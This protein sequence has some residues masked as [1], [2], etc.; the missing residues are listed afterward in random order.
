MF[1]R[2]LSF[3]EQQLLRPLSASLGPPT[4]WLATLKP[5]HGIHD[6]HNA[7]TV[8]SKESFVQPAPVAWLCGVPKGQSQADA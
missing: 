5:A 3:H 1:F 2:L 6:H 8:R 7:A 4:A